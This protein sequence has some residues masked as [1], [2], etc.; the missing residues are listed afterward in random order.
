MKAPSLKA[1]GLIRLWAVAARAT[2]DEVR[3]M[4]SALRNLPQ[5]AAAVR[6][7]GNWLA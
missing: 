7:T 3:P 6:K 5:G 4:R 2:I 1:E